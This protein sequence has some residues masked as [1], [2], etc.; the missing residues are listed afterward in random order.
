MVWVNRSEVQR[1]NER[2]GILIGFREWDR[3]AWGDV[4]ELRYVDIKCR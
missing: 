1:N 4:S 2:I 3:K